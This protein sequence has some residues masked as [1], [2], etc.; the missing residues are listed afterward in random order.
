M[1]QRFLLLY[2][3]NQNEETEELQIESHRLAEVGGD[4]WRSSYPTP[5]A[6]Q[7]HLQQAA[8]PHGHTRFESIC[9]TS[10]TFELKKR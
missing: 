4:L 6:K 9:D 3:L 1:G 8:Q 7:S 10:N 2:R 5:L